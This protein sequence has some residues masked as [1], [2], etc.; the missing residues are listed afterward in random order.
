ME[1]IDTHYQEKMAIESLFGRS[2]P[3][4]VIDHIL[5]FLF[6]NISYNTEYDEKDNIISHTRMYNYRDFAEGHFYNDRLIQLCL[7]KRGTKISKFYYNT[8]NIRLLQ[9][10]ENGYKVTSSTYKK[11]SGELIRE[12][13]R[14]KY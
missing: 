12:I 2:G 9:I 13:I 11:Q 3:N 1:Q 6:G 4:N 10:E 14:Y 8:G 5:G 7:N